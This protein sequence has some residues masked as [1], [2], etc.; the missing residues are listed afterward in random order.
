MR[1]QLSRRT[2]LK[3]A[4]A[5]SATVI[6]FD[7]CARSRVTQARAETPS[8]EGLPKLDGLLLQDEAP[9]QA[10][11]VDRG[12]IFHRV[13]AGVLDP[14]SRQDVVRMVR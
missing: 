11:A 8:L 9:R 6:G 4:A 7:P 3:L 5:S 2:A 1:R 10:I 12:N 14:G 13:P